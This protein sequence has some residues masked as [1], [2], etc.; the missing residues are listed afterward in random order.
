MDVKAIQADPNF[1][2]EKDKDR[3]KVENIKPVVID[4]LADHIETCF[5]SA[6]RAKDEAGINE[7]LNKCMRQ[8]KGEYDPDILTAINEQ[9]GT[10]VYRKLT[11]LKC[12]NL[13]A[14]IADIMNPVDHKPW[15]L[16]PTP[17]PEIPPDVMDNIVALA[18]QA[19]VMQYQP[20]IMQGQ[21]IPPDEI[22]NFAFESAFSERKR[23]LKEAMDIA[24][25]R[26]KA[27]EKTIE[28]QMLEGNWDNSFKDFV[29]DF[30]IFPNAIIKGP[31][32]RKE[33][34]LKWEKDDFGNVS[35]KTEQATKLQFERV[36]PYDIYP[37]PS[38]K[39]IQDSY[40]IEVMRFTR[41][42]LASMRGL[43]HYKTDAINEILDMRPGDIKQETDQNVEYT[44]NQLENRQQEPEANNSDSKIDALSFWG[45]VPGYLLKDWGI[46]N[47]EDERAEYEISAIKVRHRVIKAM[48]NEHPLKQRPYSM[49][50]FKKVPGS[51][52]GISLPET[53]NDIQQICNASIRAMCN[54]AAISSGPIL[55][56]DMS[57][58]IAGQEIESLRPW[59]M[60]QY[61]GR[62]AVNN[63]DPIKAFDIP[64]NVNE[65][66]FVYG[67]MKQEADD[68]TGV[69][70]FAGGSTQ[71]GG[72]AET[73]SGLAMLQGNY[74]KL[75]KKIVIEMGLNIYKTVIDRCY[76]HNMLYNDDEEIKGD[77]K[78]DVRGP[79]EVL[80]REQIQRKMMEIMQASNNPVDQQIIDINKRRNLWE[81][82][83]DGFNLPVED[84]VP[85]EDELKEKLQMQQQM[86]MLN[87][88][89][90]PEQER[91][92]A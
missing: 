78:I 58:I 3:I 83:L 80:A 51:F 39:G 55:G 82:W 44:K 72:A 4:M 45:S 11:T 74:N 32:Q 75:I 53:M 30:C 21:E 62:K 12:D 56:Y 59:M 81:K 52:W 41:G 28:D 65:L 18:E 40:L 25:R 76:I 70:A 73:A 87:V 31:V 63:R 66:L 85:S 19:T 50:S 68:A 77:I 86:A 79:I 54:N 23:I 33:N 9:G 5:N 7:R 46:K 91:K 35:V 92:T 2:P 64:N 69:P 61:D 67:K 13:G 22:E 57:Q 60:I 48:I 27:M 49:D 24:D 90:S 15:A 34:S 84:V 14:W 43:K 26:A 29:S 10:K 47:I 71:M 17:M 16:Y 36:S 37:G 1:V 88:P 89:P 42:E 38:S 20:L 8:Y 6:K